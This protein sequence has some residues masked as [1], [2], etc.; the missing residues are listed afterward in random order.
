M[1]KA[2]PELIAAIERTIN[3]LQN[4]ASYEWG[5]MGACNCGNLAQELTKISK[6]EIHKFA[7]QKHGDWNE[8]LIDYCPS[9]GFPMDLMV[10]KML[11]FGLTLDDL[12]HL[13]R[14][15]D[16]EILA[17]MDK[18]KKDQLNKNSRE[19]LVF[20][21]QIWAKLLREKWINQ[22]PFILSINSEKKLKL[23]ALV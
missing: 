5:H 6:A 17:L 16:P 9:S 2:N 22:A 11:E 8:Q 19:D 14:L 10:S 3:K 13:E 7:M 21:L 20:Y 23:P 18:E 1:A 12:S 15:S 4:G